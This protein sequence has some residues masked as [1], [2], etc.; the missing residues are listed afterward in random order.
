MY[1]FWEGNKNLELVITCSGH[2][3]HCNNT[4]KRKRN[5]SSVYCEAEECIIFTK[6]AYISPYTCISIS[7]PGPQFSN[8]HVHDT[9]WSNVFKQFDY[10]ENSY[11]GFLDIKIKLKN[12]SNKESFQKQNQC[13]NRLP[14][15]PLHKVK[16]MYKSKV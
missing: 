14:L 13:E 5:V 3:N 2:F 11:F 1:G 8:S 9:S 16:F 6:V 15:L 10:N 7:H 4:V 12:K